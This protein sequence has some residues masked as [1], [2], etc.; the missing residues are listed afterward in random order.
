MEKKG[1]TISGGRENGE[2][3]GQKLGE[4]V[5]CFCLLSEGDGYTHTLGWAFVPLEESFRRHHA[6]HTEFKNTHAHTQ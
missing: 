5:S 6:V 1:K 4:D 2:L 3:R